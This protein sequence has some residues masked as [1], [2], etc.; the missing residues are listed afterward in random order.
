MKINW[1]YAIGEL[2]IVTVGIL[3]AF[4][5]NNWAQG[6]LED[7]KQTV[8][9]KSLSDDLSADLEV[10]KDNLAFVK[11]NQQ[12]A[13][14]IIGHFHRTLPGRDSVPFK[15]FSELLGMPTFLPHDATYQTLNS[16]GDFRLV[17]DME[18]KNQIVDHYSRYNEIF[19]EDDQTKAFLRDHVSD[20]FMN[21]ASFEAIHLQ[22]DE[23]LNDHRLRNIVYAWFGI[24]K[25]QTQILERN[26]ERT[27]ALINAI[28]AI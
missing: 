24:Y 27:E 15:I 14:S 4:G 5:L 17:E 9:L 12:K 20:F 25:I 10:L 26:I 16:S 1:K 19:M 11:R 8:Y 23:L 28:E 21:E 13:R 2:L 18:L 6:K 3:I 7:R 22:A